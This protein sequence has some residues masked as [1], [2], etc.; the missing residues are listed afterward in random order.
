MD[1]RSGVTDARRRAGRRHGGCISRRNP[2]R[3]DT[4]MRLENG[5]LIYTFSHIF[6][7]LSVLW[8]WCVVRMPQ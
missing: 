4:G 1:Q 8:G 6:A 7:E 2:G 5:I 3:E